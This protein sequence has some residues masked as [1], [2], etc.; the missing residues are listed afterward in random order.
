MNKKQLARKESLLPNG[1]PKYVRCYDDG[2]IDKGGY[3][4]RYTVIYSGNYNNI[5]KSIR[6]WKNPSYH[7][8]GMSSQPFQPQGCWWHGEDDKIIDLDKWGWAPA[9]G[10]KNHLG[11]RIPFSELPPDCQKLVLSD[12]I[13]IWNLK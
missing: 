1:I 11:K 6:G 5:G 9:M 3:C 12:Y 10:R 2:G 7:Y 8:M 4:D 13:D